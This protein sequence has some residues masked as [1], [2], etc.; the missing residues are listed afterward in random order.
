MNVF[1][2]A[3]SPAP[4]AHTT[5]LDPRLRLDYAARRHRATHYTPLDVM[6]KRG[7]AAAKAK[8]GAKRGAAKRGAAKSGAA[9][10]SAKPKA[11]PMKRTTKRP[12]ADA[13]EE[14][15]DTMPLMK[16][17]FGEDDGHEPT[18]A[19]DD[20]SPSSSS[21]SSSSSES[22]G[23]DDDSKGDA[24]MLDAEGMEGDPEQKQGKPEEPP[25]EENGEPRESEPEYTALIR[26][27]REPGLL[28]E[29]GILTFPRQDQPVAAPDGFASRDTYLNALIKAMIGRLSDTDKQQLWNY[30]DTFHP[31]KYASL[32]AGTECPRVVINELSTAITEMGGTSGPVVHSWSAEV[33][34]AKRE[35]IRLMF[36]NTQHLFGD[37]KQC[38]CNKS[39]R[40]FAPD[41]TDDPKKTK[42]KSTVPDDAKGYIAGFPC[43]S[44][45]GPNNQ[46]KEF[47]ECVKDKTGVT[48]LPTEG[49]AGDVWRYMEPFETDLAF[50]VPRP[51]R[52]ASG[53]A[54]E[55][56]GSKTVAAP[57]A[58]AG[59]RSADGGGS[60]IKTSTFLG[61][62]FLES[63]I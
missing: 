39:S 38:V 19:A 5:P 9:K 11:P 55:A 26:E 36:P 7:S 2:P 21:S 22:L 30:F 50:G 37:V 8:A 17:L 56:G 46:A 40:D 25:P 12:A 49:A 23:S 47:R 58:E 57:P 43:K 31:L 52:K 10:R 18:A 13:E 53:S 20:S 59:G 24:G 27:S 45:A 14:E 62:G 42:A 16:S 1:F 63:P 54:A 48:G 6:G 51:W 4:L 34:P 35:F 28:A 61:P 15:S 60:K 29:F 33:D 44:V 3:P 32:C 41:K